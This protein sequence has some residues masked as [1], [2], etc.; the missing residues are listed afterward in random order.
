MMKRNDLFDSAEIARLKRKHKTSVTAAVLIGG[1]ALLVCVLL[2]VFTRT[3]N[4]E[5]MTLTA[6]AV[7]TV[8]GWIMLS[9]LMFPATDARHELRHA[10]FRRAAS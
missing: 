7:S 9:L 5:R 8:G 3:G 4:A 1:L 2:C 6:I 10:G